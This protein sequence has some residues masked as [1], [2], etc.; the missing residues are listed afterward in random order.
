MRRKT[1][2]VVDDSAFMRKIVSDMISEDPSFEVI[3]TAKNGKEAVQKTIDLKPDAITL[4]IEMPL[5][6]GLEA[7]QAIMQQRPT[8]VIML[9]SLTE[10]GARET[11]RALELGAFDFV[12]KPSGSISLDIYK[13]R[14]LLLEKL[15]IALLSSAARIAKTTSPLRTAP[16]PVRAGQG[17]TQPQRRRTAPGM[18]AIVAIGTST[19]GPKALNTVLSAIPGRFAAPI[20]VVQHMPPGF[21]KS[22]ANR[23]DSIC[24]LHV[25]EAEQHMT[26]DSGT[27]YI[28]PGGYHMKLGGSSGQY[29]I[30]LSKEAIRSGHRPSVD[31][32]FESLVAYPELQRYAVIMTGMG[33]D[34]ASAM[35]KLKESGAAGLIAEAEETCIVYGMPR[36]AIEQKA[37][38]HIVR[39]P[40]IAGKLVELVGLDAAT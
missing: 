1:V 29:R 6:N 8:P 5:M 15:R 11:I 24:E 31:V 9:S 40:N 14:D 30:E 28:A 36:A 34:G 2:L 26:V 4:D 3:D 37:V 33:A 17:L 25:V 32:M 13:V 16:E 12:R 27:V 23:L 10:E 35:K 38:D 22:L 20:L 19:G 21:T 7:L 39:L 18:D